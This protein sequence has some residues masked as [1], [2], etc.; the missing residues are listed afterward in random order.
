MFTVSLHS[1]S[2]SLRISHHTRGSASAAEPSGCSSLSLSLLD[3]AAAKLLL[4][5]PERLRFGTVCHAGNASEV[6]RAAELMS[7]YF[8]ATASSSAR[9]VLQRAAPLLYAAPL[10]LLLGGCSALTWSGPLVDKALTCAG[11]EYRGSLGRKPSAAAC[12]AAAE[13]V[14]PADLNYAVWRDQSCY[15]CAITTRGDPSAWVYNKVVGA[16][17]FAATGTLAPTPAPAPDLHNP[18]LDGAG[19]QASRKWCDAAAPI[20]ERVADMVSRMNVSEK[21]SN[22]GNSA[23]AIGSLDLPHYNWWSEATHGLATGGLGVRNSAQAPHQTNFPFPITTAMS[24]NRT[25]WRAT[26]AQI[27]TEARAFMNLGAA[28]S[29]Y[30]APVINLAREPR[31]GRNIECPGEDPFLT[32]EYAVQFVQ[33]FERNPADPAHIQASACCKHFAAN[34]MEHATEAGQTHTRHDFSA[35]ITQQDLVDSYLAPF[36]ACVERGRVSG[37]MCSYNAVNGVPACANDWLLK[38]V[39]REAWGFDGYVTSDCG[40]VSDA[41]NKHH[42]TGTPEA[43][44]AAALRAGTDND[45]GAFYKQHVPAALNQSLISIADVDAALA[46]LFKVRVRLLYSRLTSA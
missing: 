31:W 14:V 9:M 7:S 33:G 8:I 3:G 21:I 1:I 45:C 6:S 16:V 42:F 24:F 37:L 13:A 28:Y 34:S 2:L 20:D 30:W 11:G 46:R 29:T 27:G 10:L 36:Q 26:G 39:A 4:L 32:S 41:F 15:V 17:S 5:A 12:L 23:G 35:N 22:L 44:A 40:A 18:C 19:A 25:L 38:D 43:T